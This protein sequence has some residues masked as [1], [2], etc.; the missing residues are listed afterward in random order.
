MSRRFD[1]I[2]A[3]DIA[4]ARRAG[5]HGDED[6]QRAYAQ[7]RIANVI[8]AKILRGDTNAINGYW[9]R[10]DPPKQEQA[11]SAGDAPTVVNLPSFHYFADP[12]KADPARAATTD[13]N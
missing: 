7:S 2:R 11:A 6:M 10:A 8:A 3:I 13:G 4:I 9:D 5:I 12:T 1:S